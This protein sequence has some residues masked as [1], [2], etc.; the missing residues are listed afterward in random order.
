MQ[1]GRLQSQLQKLDALQCQLKD[2]GSLWAAGSSCSERCLSQSLGRQAQWLA[3]W[4]M[5]KWAGLLPSC[6]VCART[7]SAR[8]FLPALSAWR[9]AALPVRCCC[10]AHFAPLTGHAS[11]PHICSL[12]LYTRYNFF[13]CIAGHGASREPQG[14]SVTWSLSFPHVLA[15]S[16]RLSLSSLQSR[17]VLH[18]LS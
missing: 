16:T 6:P 18:L 4:G 15:H 12:C 10:S 1:R 11:G 5:R 3:A 9:S 17:G 13:S 7:H 2:A 14:R 8:L